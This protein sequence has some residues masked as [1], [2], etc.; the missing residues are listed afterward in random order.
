[1]RRGQRQETRDRIQR[2]KRLEA[3]QKTEL[4]DRRLYTVGVRQD[5]LDR[6]CETGE[7]RSEARDVRQET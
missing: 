3:G 5:T 2:D 6:S 7:R 1:M 4:R